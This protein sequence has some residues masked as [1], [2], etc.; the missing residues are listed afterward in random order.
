M[1]TESLTLNAE[2]TAL[3]VAARSQT[4]SVEGDLFLAIADA[5]A[6]YYNAKRTEY[7]AIEKQIEVADA[8]GTLVQGTDGEG[9]PLPIGGMPSRPRPK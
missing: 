2:Q 5:P 7:L 9:H 4:V 6:N 1:A 8:A 3:T